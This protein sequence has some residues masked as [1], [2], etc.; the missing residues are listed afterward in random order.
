MSSLRCNNTLIGP[1]EFG[2]IVNAEGFA[3]CLRRKR[4]KAKTQPQYIIII[5]IIIIIINNEIDNNN[6]I[7]IIIINIKK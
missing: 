6:N 1:F 3:V 4:T 7:I 5:I 2:S